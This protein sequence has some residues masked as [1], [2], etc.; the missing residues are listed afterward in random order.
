MQAVWD[1]KKAMELLAASSK[2][3]NSDK[4]MYVEIR[5]W[6]ETV[7]DRADS[8]RGISSELQPIS[9]GC[10][11]ETAVL[12]EDSNDDRPRAELCEGFFRRVRPPADSG[13]RACASLAHAMEESGHC[14]DNLPSLSSLSGPASAFNRTVEQVVAANDNHAMFKIDPQSEEKVSKEKRL[15]FQV[16]CLVRFTALRRFELFIA[17]AVLLANC[18]RKMPARSIA[19][20]QFVMSRELGIFKDEINCI[21]TENVKRVPLNLSPE[22]VLR[23]C[24]DLEWW[25]R[26]H[27]ICSQ[28]VTVQRRPLLRRLDGSPPW[29]FRFS[30]VF[31][32]VELDFPQESSLQLLESIQWHPEGGVI[33]VP[34]P[35]QAVALLYVVSAVV[36]SIAVGVFN[37]GNR[38]GVFERVSD[39]V[40]TATVLLVSVFGL[41]KLTSED[42]NAIRNVLFGRKV[43]RTVRDIKNAVGASRENDLKILVARS[44]KEMAWL[45]QDGSS[46]ATGGAGGS[47][48]LTRG[49]RL[50]DF[51]GAGWRIDGCRMVR[52]ESGDGKG[53]RFECGS[54]NFAVID[55]ANVNLPYPEFS[56]PSC[57]KE[58]Q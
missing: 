29:Y 47:I 51:Y 30:S 42:E 6:L 24:I 15:V 38:D 7:E 22:A 10:L 55:R 5:L 3:R 32:C 9:A 48:R 21:A 4:V 12:I 11:N 39:A 44:E 23:L 8:F 25:D 34:K 49:M 19:K 14:F 16:A 20:A 40:Q 37:V 36:F 33:N 17:A 54:D 35:K 43:L 46:Y 50:S 45:D 41:L 53:P 27:A 52:V 18:D 57:P 1:M 31:F 58:V 13:G 28:R 2:V 56:N 26:A